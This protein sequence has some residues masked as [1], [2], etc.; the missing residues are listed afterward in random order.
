MNKLLEQAIAMKDEI[1]S[2]RR[3]IHNNPEVELNYLKQ[4]HMLWIS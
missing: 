1:I 4:K 3:T 2:Y